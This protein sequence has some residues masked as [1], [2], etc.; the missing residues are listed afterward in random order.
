MM[1]LALKVLDHG[2]NW[3]VHLEES[4]I[5]NTYRYGLSINVNVELGVEV[6]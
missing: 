3:K 5:I 4:W 2:W 1:S 6:L